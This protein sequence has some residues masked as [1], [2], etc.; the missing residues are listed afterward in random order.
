MEENQRIILEVL[1]HIRKWIN[2]RGI[3]ENKKKHKET[4]ESLKYII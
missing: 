2:M 4:T 1:S 3:S